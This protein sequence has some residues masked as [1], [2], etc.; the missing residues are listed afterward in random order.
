MERFQGIEFREHENLVNYFTSRVSWVDF[1][2]NVAS[3][4]RP[5][6]FPGTGRCR[7]SRT[8]ATCP[9]G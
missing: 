1:S 9:P 4:A 2:V 3:G 5:N 8:S 6:F 7:S